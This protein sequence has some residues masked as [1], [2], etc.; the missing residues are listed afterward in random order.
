[1]VEQV[2][3]VA[4]EF[5]TQM[6]VESQPRTINTSTPEG[7]INQA[8]LFVK[9][10]FDIVASLELIL[11]L[12]IPMALI[13]VMIRLDSPGSSIFKQERLG[14][15]GKPFII[16][17]FRTMRT[18]APHDRAT[19]DFDNSEQYVTK[20]GSWLRKTSLDEL[21]QLINI[22]KGD[23]SFV[24]YRPVCTTEDDLNQIR[25]ECGVFKVKPGLTGLAQI[26]GRDNIVDYKEK[27]LLD[28]E[29]LRK[30]SIKMDI[31]CLLKTIMVV[32]S[33]DG[34]K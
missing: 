23:M 3:S 11:L 14:K 33:G 4:D 1:M 25:A 28:I 34:A 31:Y 26:R 6:R 27:A 8:Y 30:Q 10:T 9:R 20:F 2:P 22:L 5:A 32:L 7:E 16:L 29:Y 12:C 18:D 19:R 15:N 21:P 24:G 13:A 17:K